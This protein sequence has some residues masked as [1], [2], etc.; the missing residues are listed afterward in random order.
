MLTQYTATI[1]TAADGSATVYLGSAIRGYVQMFRYEPG[2]LDN[3]TDVVITGETTGHAILTQANLGGSALNI[4]PRAFAHQVTD[5]AAVAVVT[6]PI[7]V[8]N[9]RIKVVVAQGGNTKTGTLHVFIEEST[10]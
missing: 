8:Y 3:G 5:G 2:T 4:Y 1:T 10:W 6:E 9:E 7:A